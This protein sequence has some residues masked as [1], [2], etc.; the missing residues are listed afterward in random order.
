MSSSECTKESRCQGI[1]G[2]YEM[3]LG[4]IAL[5]RWSVLPVL[6]GENSPQF[7]YTAGLSLLGFPELIMVGIPDD[8]S[9]PILNTIGRGFVAGDIEASHGVVI[10]EV[11]TTDCQLF[12][13]SVGAMHKYMTLCRKVS[14]RKNGGFKAL[15]VVWPDK[16]GRYPWVAGCNHYCACVQGMLLEGSARKGAN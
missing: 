13:V 10:E 6:E 12:A 14:Q 11:A 8:V 4:Q 3:T 1:D 16:A 15:Q 2:L 7:A 5:G 9:H